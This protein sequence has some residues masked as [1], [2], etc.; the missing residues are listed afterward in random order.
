MTQAVVGVFQTSADAEH[1]VADL[2]EKGFQR[3]KIS[4]IAPNSPHAE[5]IHVAGSN[6]EHGEDMAIGAVGGGLVGGMLGALVGMIVI[7][8][9]GL[10]PVLVAGPIAAAIGG[11]GVTMALGAGAGAVGG[12]VL[13][14]LTWAGITKDEAHVYEDFL[15]EGKTLVMVQT[16]N[17]KR[18]QAVEV[19]HRDGAADAVELEED[20][21]HEGLI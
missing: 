3:E 14:A 12:G 10:G 16:S 7:A 18:A 15:K 6:V 2:L 11:A 5:H 8:I 17:E 1:A 21:R 4:L 20:W 13:G 19:L 9:P